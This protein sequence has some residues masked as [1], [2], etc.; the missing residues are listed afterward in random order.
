MNRY[1]SLKSGRERFREGTQNLVKG[2][3]KVR[4]VV[5]VQPRILSLEG[6]P[7]WGSRLLCQRFSDPTFHAPCLLCADSRHITM[8]LRSLCAVGCW[9]LESRA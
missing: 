1:A 9:K 4:H 2:W 8:N 3:I 5:A 7:L 6:S